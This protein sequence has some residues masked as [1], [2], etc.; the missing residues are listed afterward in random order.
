MT[1]VLGE[2]V[3]K[4]IKFTG[5]GIE[6]AKQL[7]DALSRKIQKEI[8]FKY[9]SVLEGV[10][11]TQHKPSNVVPGWGSRVSLI[12]RTLECSKTQR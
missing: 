5:N 7:N 8:I 6:D 3:L 11:P 12:I 10:M 2:D 9:G 1:Q 4:D